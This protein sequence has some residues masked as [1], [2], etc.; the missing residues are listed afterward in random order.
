MHLAELLFNLMLAA[1]HLAAFFFVRDVTQHLKE[2]E[3]DQLS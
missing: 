3:R 1:F 2:R